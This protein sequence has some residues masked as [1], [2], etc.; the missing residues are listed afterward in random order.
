M[1]SC[2]QSICWKLRSRGCSAASAPAPAPWCSIE[3]A[4]RLLIASRAR[5]QTQKKTRG[6]YPARAQSHRSRGRTPPPQRDDQSWARAGARGRARSRRFARSRAVSSASF[7]CRSARRSSRSL[8]QE[9]PARV[10]TAAV[11]GAGLMGS[12][13]AHW[14]AT[15]GHRVILR[16]VDAARVAAGMENIAQALRGR[17]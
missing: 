10:G 9:R 4:V 12:A 7:S 16:D 8:A 17:A 6:H 13:I 5:E 15:R 14:I 1:R 2:R 11:I 3:R